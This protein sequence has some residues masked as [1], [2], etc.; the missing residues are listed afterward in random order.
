[1][2]DI[3]APEGVEEEFAGSSLDMIEI[4]DDDI[5]L[6]QPQDAE[7]EA[8]EAESKTEA[9]QKKPDEVVVETKPEKRE[10]KRADYQARIN[11]LTR[12]R[13]E[14]EERAAAAEA[15]LSLA[16]QNAQREKPANDPYAAL[17]QQEAELLSRRKAAEEEA[18][19]SEYSKVTDELTKVRFQRMRAEE[20]QQQEA[21][22][23]AESPPARQANQEDSVHPS[24]ADWMSKNDWYFKPENAHLAREAQRM[25]AQ[26]RSRGHTLGDGLYKALNEEL[27]KLPEFDDVLVGEEKEVEIEP[28][29]PQAKPR[30]I[31]PPSRGGEPPARPKP[32]ELSEY[33][34]Q[35]MRR[36]KLD[37]ND[38]KQRQAYLQAKR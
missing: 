21:S 30:H 19:L 38:P 17:K 27:A 22:R 25:E 37:P 32:G 23:K 14:A 8:V 24:A 13:H 4:P 26:L 3:S 7:P 31:A 33:D 11:E 5:A 36:F 16:E 12:A 28:S 20:L 9:E 15:R 10:R 34:K 2:P 35:T 29:K 1:M 18:D 6:L